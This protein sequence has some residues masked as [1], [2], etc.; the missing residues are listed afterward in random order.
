MDE[1]ASALLRICFAIIFRDWDIDSLLFADDLELLSFDRRG[2]ELVV[3]AVFL[4]T[5]LGAPVKAQKF[6]GGFQTDWIGLHTCYKSYSLGLSELGALFPVA[7]FM[8]QGH[9]QRW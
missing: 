6:R 9:R 5:M 4:L 3:V 2:R 1:N 7:L 8:D